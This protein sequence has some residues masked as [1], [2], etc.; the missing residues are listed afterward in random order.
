MLNN[1]VSNLSERLCFQKH[2]G[3]FEPRFA[4]H[5]S[6]VTPTA[7]LKASECFNVILWVT[8]SEFLGENAGILECQ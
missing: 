1:R 8:G 3:S 7:V 2:H 6:R 5:A 4:R